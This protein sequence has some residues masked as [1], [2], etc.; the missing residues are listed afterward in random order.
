MGPQQIFSTVHQ[1]NFFTVSLN[2]LISTGKGTFSSTSN[3][4]AAL[5]KL[6]KLVGTLSN[7]SIPNLSTSDFKSAKSVILG[8]FA[9]STTV[10]FLKSAFLALLYA[11]LIQI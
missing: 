1:K 8:K 11:N 3:L 9:P 4:Y 6:L 2:L 5:F 10:A 7:L